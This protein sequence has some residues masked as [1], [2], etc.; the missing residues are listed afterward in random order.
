MSCR[1]FMPSSVQL[2]ILNANSQLQRINHFGIELEIFQD[3]STLVLLP[4]GILNMFTF[5]GHFFDDFDNFF[6]A[7]CHFAHEAI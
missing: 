4:I 7:L 5:S 2:I 6:V 3:Y 1:L